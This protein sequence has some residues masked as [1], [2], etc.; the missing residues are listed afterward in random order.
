MTGGRGPSTLDGGDSS[1]ETPEDAKGPAWWVRHRVLV[2]VAVV[3]AAALVA[4][5]VVWV[6]MPDRSLGYD[7]AQQGANAVMAE[8]RSG[9][10]ADFYRRNPA[11]V[12]NIDNR[13]A[14]DPFDQRR[15]HLVTWAG[16]TNTLHDYRLVGSRAE[17]RFDPDA[18][19]TRSEVLTVYSVSGLET[20]VFDDTSRSMNGQ[21]WLYLAEIDGRWQLVETI[22]MLTDTPGIGPYYSR[23]GMPAPGQDR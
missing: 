2:V 19:R 11:Y 6:R 13:A 15:H 3:V 21:W 7:S 17:P 10:S 8:I 4:T 5:V 9:D 20:N 22:R 14:V 16:L 23:Q 12:N 1:V 18:Q